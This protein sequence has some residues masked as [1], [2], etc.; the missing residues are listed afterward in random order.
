MVIN[1]VLS[2]AIFFV[3]SI[4]SISTMECFGY[5]SIFFMIGIMIVLALKSFG[6]SCTIVHFYNS[7][8]KFF[9][10]RPDWSEWIKHEETM[11]N[12]YTGSIFDEVWERSYCSKCNKMKRRKYYEELDD[13]IDGDDFD[14]DHISIVRVNFDE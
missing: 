3:L 9:P 1:F 6:I 12:V 14:N 8:D 2:I 7:D 10:H 13:D 11:R 4:F 5:S